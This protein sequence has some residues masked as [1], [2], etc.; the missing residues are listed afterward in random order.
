[1]QWERGSRDVDGLE[2]IGTTSASGTMGDMNVSVSSGTAMNGVSQTGCGTDFWTQP[3]LA[4]PAYTGGTVSNAPTPCE[5]VG[6]NSAN[7]VTVTFSSPID[8]LYMALL[9][10]GAARSGGDLRLRS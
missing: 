2:S 6:L 10:V 1:M 3:N 4:D 7:R 8:S 9:S 5:Q